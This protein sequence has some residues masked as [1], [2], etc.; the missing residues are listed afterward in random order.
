MTITTESYENIHGHKPSRSQQGD[1]CFVIVADN[2][3]EFTFW[4]RGTYRDALRAVKIEAVAKL[5]G[6]TTIRVLP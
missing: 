2:E 4:H 6:A 1:W 3:V 5:I